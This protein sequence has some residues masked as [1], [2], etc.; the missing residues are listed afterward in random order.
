MSVCVCVRKGAAYDGSGWNGEVQKQNLLDLDVTAGVLP[1]S[2]LTISF[3]LRTRASMHLCERVRTRTS[4]RSHTQTHTSTLGILE[5][6]TLMVPH[7]LFALSLSLTCVWWVGRY[8]NVRT[9]DNFAQKCL[10]S[11]VCAVTRR[12]GNPKCTVGDR[13]QCQR[14]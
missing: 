7:S 3:N 10:Q 12:N 2:E 9:I 4:T 14:C 6:T 8:N 13:A 11:N 1:H 5:C